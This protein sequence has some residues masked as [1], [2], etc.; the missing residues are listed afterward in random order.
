[1]PE[2]GVPF[3]FPVAKTFEY[4]ISFSHTDLGNG[5]TSKKALY[6]LEVKP[7]GGSNWQYKDVPTVLNRSRDRSDMVELLSQK[8]D[9]SS[10]LASKLLRR[11]EGVDETTNSKIESD[12]PKRPDGT[13]PTKPLPYRL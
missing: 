6:I 12:A 9:I 11:A 8:F 4:R 2:T 1:M 13:L 5:K 7:Y 10:E 3:E